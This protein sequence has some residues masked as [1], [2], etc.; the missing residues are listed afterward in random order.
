MKTCNPFFSVIVPVYKVEYYLSKC[1][2]SILGQ[3]FEDFELILVDDGSPDDCP[4]ICDFYAS[5]DRRIKV[6]HKTN[7]GLAE[8][9]N[10]GLL[11]M[12]EVESNE[13]DKGF[14]IFVDSD[15]YLCDN[16]TFQLIYDRARRFNEDMVLYGCKNVYENGIEVVT[17]GHYPIEILNEHNKEKSLKALYH[18]NNLPGA[19]WIYAIRRSLVKN[20]NLKFTKGVT[21]E[22]YEWIISSLV[23][24]DKIGAIEGVHYA[25]VK[26]DGSIT[27]KIRI[28]A[29]RGLSAAIEKYYFYKKKYIVLDAFLA[30][31]YL[32]AVMSY[33]NL[34]S[35]DKNEAKYILREYMVILR[36]ANFNI[37]YFLIR[38]FG[39]QLSSMAVRYIYN[40]LK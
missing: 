32:L 33:N 22:D 20:N 15:D 14:I 3:T 34:P 7:G 39:L 2:N 13:N 31:A 29:Y 16:D 12:S 10:F 36:S 30:K 4:R 8:A 18:R 25:Y 23:L 17:R 9:R 26:R 27:T 37:P 35:M 19:A 5:R 24:S 38:T 11:A 28:T 1:I 6:I 40:L 21:A